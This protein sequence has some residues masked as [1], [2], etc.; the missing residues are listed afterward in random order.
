VLARG[1][2]ITG[3]EG[4]TILKSKQLKSGM[5]IQTTFLDGNIKSTVS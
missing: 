3:H 1:Y 5:E 2:T 4:V